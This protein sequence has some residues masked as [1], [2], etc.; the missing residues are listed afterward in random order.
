MMSLFRDYFHAD[1]LLPPD[2]TLLLLRHAY[3]FIAMIAALL[4]RA[5]MRRS[6]TQWSSYSV[7]VDTRM[8]LP[9]TALRR[10]Y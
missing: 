5:L 8:M 4:S 6:D 3:C 1:T 7:Y 10:D 9:D 2:I